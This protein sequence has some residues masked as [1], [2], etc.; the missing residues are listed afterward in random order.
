MLK[1]LYNMMVEFDY[2][3]NG[4]DD[5]IAFLKIMTRLFEDEKLKEVQNENN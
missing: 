2:E 1:N 5:T 4:L 3:K